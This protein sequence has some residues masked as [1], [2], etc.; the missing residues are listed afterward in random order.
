MEVLGSCLTNKYSEGEVGARYY[1][2]NEFID[3]VEQMCKTRALAAYRLDA[4]EWSVNVAPYSGS[5]ANFAVYTALLRPHDRI[6]GLDLPHG[7]HLTHG[8]Y[9]PTKKIS[10]SSIFFESLPYHVTEAGVID[11]DELD[12]VALVFRPKLIIAGASA[13]SLELDYPRFRKAADSCG[14]LLM[15]DMAHISGLVAA[16][17]QNN[18]FEYADVVTTTTHKSLR[19]PRA[20]MI[21][22]R[23]K[24]ADGSQTGFPDLIDFAVFPSLQGGPHQHQIGAI[25]TQLKQ[26]MSPEFKEYAKQVKSNA[27][28]FAAELMSKGYT[29][30]SGGTQN[31][32]FLLDLRPQGLTGSKV[33]KV[34]ELASITVNKNSVP[35]DRSS[36]SPSGIRFGT[37]ALTTRGLK[38]AEFKQIAE[39]VDRAVKIATAVQSTSGK[40]LKPFLAALPNNED[41]KALSKEVEAFAITFPMPGL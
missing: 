30:V 31:H 37:P 41:L 19:G 28:T 36:I 12:R 27:H 17:E 40:M 15:V 34:L 33:E 22:S 23:K 26:V 16:Q 9:T 24:R 11:Y 25:A 6:M 39:F 10:A 4:E 7:G 13:Y 20:G 32:L 8:Y 21:F 1:G 2:G 35:G 14:A 29:V 5:P 18:P 3:Q 38:E